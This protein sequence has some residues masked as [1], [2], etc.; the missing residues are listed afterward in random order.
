MG[1]PII[2][3]IPAVRLANLK[4]TQI[5]VQFTKAHASLRIYYWIR[6]HGREAFAE[7]PTRRLLTNHDVRRLDR[8]SDGIIDL[9]PHALD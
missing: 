9:E 6:Q 4:V 7:K 8:N 3:K 5:A 1:S 2:S